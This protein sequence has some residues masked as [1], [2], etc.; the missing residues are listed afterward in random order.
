MQCSIPAFTAD[1]VSFACFTFALI[2]SNE[3]HN[4]SQPGHEAGQR[5]DFR[6]MIQADNF[7]S[8]SP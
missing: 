3:D 8:A 4:A 5:A 2:I 1:Q 7:R 6:S